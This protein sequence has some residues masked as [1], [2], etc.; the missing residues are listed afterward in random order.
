MK[1]KIKPPCTFD[2]VLID[3]NDCY[4]SFRTTHAI[5]MSSEVGSGYRSVD[6]HCFRISDVTTSWLL[7]LS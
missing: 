3:P 2:V 7:D 5:Q 1:W 4:V 6:G